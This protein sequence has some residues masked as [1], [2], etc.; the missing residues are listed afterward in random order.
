MMCSCCRR[1]AAIV[2]ALLCA[3]FL[4][5]C[6][7][8]VSGVGPLV[9]KYQAQQ[10]PL[11]CQS[12]AVSMLLDYLGRPADQAVVFE[13]LASMG[14]HAAH[15]SRVAYLCERLPDKN[16]RFLYVQDPDEAWHILND[17]LAR[18]FPVLLSTRI[19]PGGHVILV[20]G[21][22]VQ[23]G[24]QW[25]IAH[26]PAGEFDFDAAEFVGSGEAVR[27]RFRDLFVRN[28]QL[29]VSDAEPPRWESWIVGT[30]EWIPIG[31]NAE[32]GARVHQI[33]TDWEMLVISPDEQC[34]LRSRQDPE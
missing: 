15:S 25:V 16:P 17:S 34:D 9:V 6:V 28:R 3:A 14:G 5:G 11:A 10:S 32:P 33:V 18:G 29:M 23:R 2:A 13:A 24:R 31:S 8:R 30:R 21:T 12:A 20:I 7:A 1:L 22:E 26:D 4:I 27:Y 19:T